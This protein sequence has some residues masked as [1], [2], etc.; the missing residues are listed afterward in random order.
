MLCYFV[1][2]CVITYFYVLFYVIICCVVSFFIDI[3]WI[4]VNF[5]M[6]FLHDVFPELIFIVLYLFVS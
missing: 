4:C 5:K 1:I 6:F 3:C 2:C